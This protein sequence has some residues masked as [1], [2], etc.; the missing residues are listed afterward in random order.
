[1]MHSDAMK[2]ASAIA[3]ALLVTVCVSAGILYKKFEDRRSI[4]IAHLQTQF[5]M[6]DGTLARLQNDLPVGTSRADVTRY[7]DSHKLQYSVIGPRITV[8]LGQIPGDGFACDRWSG[9]ISFE[10]RRLGEAAKLPDA[11]LN[12]IS[13]KKLGRCL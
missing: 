6:W 9:Y 7:L 3:I 13:L 11:K 4:A 10:F 5:A 8:N 2:K 12:G 1:M